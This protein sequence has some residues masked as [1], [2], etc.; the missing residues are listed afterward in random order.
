[1]LPPISCLCGDVIM[2]SL[3]G[4]E[5]SRC[6][7]LAGW[8]LAVAPLRAHEFWIE[9]GNFRPAAGVAVPLR[10]YVGQNFAGE[11]NIYWPEGFERYALHAA[12]VE[13]PVAGVPGDDPAGQFTL[14]QPGAGIL[15]YLSRFKD[16]AFEERGKFE[17]YLDKEGLERV[18]TLPDYAQRAA[19]PIR[20]R[21][22]RCAKS[23]VAAAGPLAAEVPADRVLGL[24]LELVA[25]RNP[26]QRQAGARLPLRLLFQGRPLP[27]ALVTAFRKADPERKHTAR[28]DAQGRAELTL[29]GGGVWLLSAVHLLPAP[30][31]SGYAWES[32]WATLTFEQPG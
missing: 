9:P 7:L 1:M 13:T 8:W 3:S 23:L 29:D 22:V 28:T 18:R 25:E 20:E 30:S 12:G 11:P 10:L 17:A 24:P 21:Y 4:R 2:F 32:W 19:T 16:V 5:L 15:I 6:L 26:Y 14:R 27:G 31:A